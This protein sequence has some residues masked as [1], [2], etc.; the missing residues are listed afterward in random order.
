M[1]RSTVVDYTKK[2]IQLRGNCDYLTSGALGW[3]DT[4]TYAVRIVSGLIISPEYYNEISFQI[5]DI[6]YRYDKE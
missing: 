5:K 2:L 6:K 1:I 4:E 3:I